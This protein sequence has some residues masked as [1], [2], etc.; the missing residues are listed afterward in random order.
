M[1]NELSR[2]VR[3][4]SQ[5]WRRNELHG[6]MDRCAIETDSVRKDALASGGTLVRTDETVW[7]ALDVS[8]GNSVWPVSVRSVISASGS[9]GVTSDE[10][11]RTSL[12]THFAWLRRLRVKRLF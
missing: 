8:A 2:F 3:G 7:S 5:R 12:D 11:D 1:C 10:Q 6:R 4:V 9:L